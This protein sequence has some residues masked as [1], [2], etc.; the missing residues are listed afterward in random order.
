MDLL[1]DFEGDAR[2]CGTVDMGC[3][4]LDTRLY[5]TGNATPGA[6]VNIKMTGMPTNPVGF[7]IGSRAY[8][9][10]LKSIFGDWYVAYPR[11]GPIHP[12]A[13]VP[14]RDAGFRPPRSS[15]CFKVSVE[16]RIPR[17]CC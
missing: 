5:Y 14:A 17:I 11:I 10:P 8:D 16:E 12:G 4:E 15:R 1:E 7:F 3:D 6:A 9:P 13:R 2:C